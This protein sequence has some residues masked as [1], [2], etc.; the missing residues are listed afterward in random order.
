MEL[1]AALIHQPKLLYLDEPTIGLDFPSQKKVREFLKYYNEQFGASILL[2]SHYM[3]DVEDLCKRTIIINEGSILYDGDLHK[4]NDLF[5]EQKI[6]RLQFSEPVAEQRLAKFGKIVSADD[7]NA[8]L[9]LPK[10]RLKE[11]S[12]A[13]LDSFP[14]VDWTIEDVAIEES[15]SMLYRKESVG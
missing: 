14:I 9:E 2:T 7:Y 11:V 5:D 12:R 4:I 1:I 6:I 8:V 13:V 3:K 10:Y 15:I